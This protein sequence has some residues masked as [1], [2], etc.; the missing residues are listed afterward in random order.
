MRRY[1]WS[2]AAVMAALSLVAVGCSSDS[3][4]PV[5]IPHDPITGSSQIALAKS[6][7]TIS[8][9]QS[10]QLTAIVPP[11]PGTTAPVISWSSSDNGVAMVTHSGVLFGLKSGHATITATRGTYSAAMTVNV[12]A[13]IGIVDFG[14]DS[15][16]ISLA[17][18]VKLP[19]RVTDTD[20]NPV[21]LSKHQVEWVSTAPAIAGS[22]RR[23]RK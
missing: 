6:A 11:A 15:L 13:G 4:A 18:S 17:Q 21:D 1:T 16:A 14:S 5:E 23:S 22:S 19:Y 2:G 20:G 3:S 12:M 8:V 7:D 9:D 10:V